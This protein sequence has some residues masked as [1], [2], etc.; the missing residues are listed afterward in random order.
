MFW[1][2]VA[3][4]TIFILGVVYFVMDADVVSTDPLIEDIT[5]LNPNPDTLGFNP[6]FLEEDIEVLESKY[7]YTTKVNLPDHYKTQSVPYAA[8][9]WC[10]GYNE[11]FRPYPYLCP[12]GLVTVGHGD[13]MS[14][15]QFIKRYKPTKAQ[16]NRLKKL[17]KEF[18]KT[19]NPRAQANFYNLS[20]K[21][22]K[23]IKLS[24][25]SSHLKKNMEAKRDVAY[26][27]HFNG[28]D[29]DEL[30]YEVRAFS[31]LY[32]SYTTKS[33]DKMCEILKTSTEGGARQLLLGTKQEDGTWKGGYCRYK[34][35]VDNKWVYR[36]SKSI[37]NK[38]DLAISLYFHNDHRVLKTQIESYNGL[39]SKYLKYGVST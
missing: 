2:L 37:A 35:K 32:F 29:R 21:Y 4:I 1:V 25:A 15:S 16:K 5:P 19:R 24:E 28:Y 31:I 8:T 30:M 23:P 22:F 9:K 18:G 26:N 12:A 27:K 20:K 6:K 36:H 33:A 3:F 14:W 17:Y 38:V 10:L 34:T 7:N 11:G 13:M 39:Q